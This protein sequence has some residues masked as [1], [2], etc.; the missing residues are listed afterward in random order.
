MMPE[1]ATTRQ[2]A[3]AQERAHRE[4]SEMF[5]KLVGR[6]FRPRNRIPQSR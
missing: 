3:D 4:R 2:I 1:I 5:H 6:V